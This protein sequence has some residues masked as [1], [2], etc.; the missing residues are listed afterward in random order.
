MPQLIDDL[1]KDKKDV[2]AYPVNESDYIDL[3]Q[4]DEYRKALEKLVIV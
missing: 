3:G 1:I 4:W 2:Y